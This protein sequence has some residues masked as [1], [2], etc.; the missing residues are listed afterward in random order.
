MIMVL[1]IL[2][3]MI[4]GFTA[5]SML[6][7]SSYI[8]WLERLS[9]AYPAGIGLITLQMFFMGLAGFSL[10]RPN[11]SALICFEIICLVAFM[12]FKRDG[13]ACD[14]I[15]KADNPD[16]RPKS[17]YELCIEAVLALWIV[18]KMGT[19]FYETSLRPIYSYDTFTNWS[20]RAKLFYY[21]NS[22]LL[23]PSS[24]DFFGKGVIHSY[25]NYPPLNPLAQ[26]WMALWVG[27]FDEVLVK[28]WTPFFLL[29]SVVY[30][31]LVIRRELNRLIAL[32]IVVMLISSPFISY[33]A[34]ESMSD[35]PLAV[36]ILFAYGSLWY[37]IM[38]RQVYLPFVGIFS[39]MAMFIKGEGT[40][41]ALLL[42]L[43]CIY[44]VLFDKRSGKYPGILAVLKVIAPYLL[45]VPWF[46]FRYIHSLGNG[47]DE[48]YPTLVFRPMIFFEFLTHIAGLQNFNVVLIFVPI[49]L[50]ACGKPD[51]EIILMLFPIVFY[52]VFFLLLY[53]VVAYYSDCQ[54][55]YVAIF[56]N[57]LTYFPAVC[58]L[59]ALLIK[60]MLADPE[61]IQK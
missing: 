35:L 12:F 46:V 6:M 48:L 34:T 17:V 15:Q 23:N 11:I 26:M 44:S 47:A 38:G 49:V 7:G 9:F 22:L 1:S 59:L 36:Y 41:I 53:I 20:V 39:V 61:T 5:V 52:S 37:V 33:H 13:N 30:L 55:L 16:S 4:L 58:L 10:N 25:G 60:K 56:R 19:I 18:I 21:S 43:V 29:S 24:Y 40:I 45:I 31:Y 51:R 32:V 57:I 50:L 8:N 28:F 14:E 27:S 42:F 2:F 3:P 54:R